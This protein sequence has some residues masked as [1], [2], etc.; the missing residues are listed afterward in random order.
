MGKKAQGVPWEKQT[1]PSVTAL[2]HH[3]MDGLRIGTGNRHEGGGGLQS[4]GL[5]CAINEP[6]AQAAEAPGVQRQAPQRP[7]VPKRMK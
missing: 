1:N 5:V 4:C 6:R 3:W 7:K 2:K